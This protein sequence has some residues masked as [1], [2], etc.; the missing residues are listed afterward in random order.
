MFRI[1][2]P[3]E[4]ADRQ[5]TPFWLDLESPTPDEFKILPTS[6]TSIHWQSKMP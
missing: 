5:D 3:A 1:S 6:S 4:V 2:R